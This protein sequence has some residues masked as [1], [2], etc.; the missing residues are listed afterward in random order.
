MT[1]A[2]HGPFGRHQARPK[3]PR[4]PPPY[5]VSSLSLVVSMA[6]AVIGTAVVAVPAFADQA[7]RC[8]T[9]TPI[10]E[11]PIDMGGAENPFPTTGL[12]D[13]ATFNRVR[14]DPEQAHMAAVIAGV[15]QDLGITSRGIRIALAVALQ[16]SSLRPDAE[17][18]PYLGLFQQQPDPS[19]GLYMKHDRSDPTGASRMFFAQ[20]LERVPMY[21][22]DPRPDWA[23]GNTVQEIRNGF[24]FA[25]FEGSA[26]ELT[27]AL[28][29]DRPTQ[30]DELIC[31][32]E[33]P[34]LVAEF[35]AGNII[36]DTVFY[37]SMAMTEADIR[38][39]ID[40]QGAD[41]ESDSCLRLFTADTRDQP[42]DRYCQAY[43]GGH[44]DA[45][46]VISKVSRACGVNPQVMLTTLQ[47]E[48]GL[49]TATDP[50]VGRY[51]AAWG[52]HCPDT[53][54]GGT[55]S[56]DPEH[57]GFVAQ[58]IGMAKQ[59]ARYRLDP[60][61][62]RHRAGQ[63]VDIAYNV[64]ESGCGSAQVTIVNTATAALY[65]Y[66]PYQPNAAS[67]AAYPGT[68]DRCSSYG[69]R[70]FYHLFVKY[71]GPTG[72]GTTTVTPTGD[73][74]AVTVPHHP[75][76][77]Q[78]IAGRT[79]TAPNNAVARGLD[80]GFR[81]LGLP[82]VWGGGGSGAGPN[83][84][85]VRGGGALNSCGAEIG[86]DC[87][88]LTAYVLGQAGYLTPGDSSGQRAAGVAVTWDDALPGD[89]VGF[90][91]HVAVYLGEIDGQR[92]ILEAPGVGSN[93]HI[94]PLSRADTDA[95]VHRYWTNAP[96]MNDAGED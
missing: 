19:T 74:P 21:D 50:D 94:V 56:C 32:S 67:L 60:E 1:A 85:C 61:K 25:Q 31:S 24:L 3:T 39:F 69:N 51:Q 62:Y 11:R 17:N 96:V 9:D 53:G 82:Y 29:S 42:A 44:D 20:L 38:A 95:H 5:R 12:P 77:P 26:A 16:Q 57:S 93:V 75:E 89:I 35:N 37:D 23:I 70:N 90:A 64:A 14:L 55:A 27:A 43:V 83:D 13:D 76:V 86:F 41:C 80:A 52:W 7:P 49:L 68:G 84:G 63:T 40:A 36:S 28:I 48:S 10:S 91:G 6:A 2:Q 46:A 78:A 8:S 30:A 87:S 88:G 66:T 47:K 79:I 15:G 45:A 34:G 33:T 65:N 92:Y 4:T 73:G 71:F 54:P 18:G 72:G 22:T 59:W 58:A 81:A